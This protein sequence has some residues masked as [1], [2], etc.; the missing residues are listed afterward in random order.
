MVPGAA[1]S[2]F[3]T[4]SCEGL[5]GGLATGPPIELAT[6][7]IPSSLAPVDGGMI[8]DDGG[9]GITSDPMDVVSES[10]EAFRT[11]LSGVKTRA[12]RIKRKK[13]LSV[14]PPDYL[15]SGDSD[16]DVVKPSQRKRIIAS[17]DREAEESVDL[18]SD[19]SNKGSGKKIDN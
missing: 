10:Q 15:L 1:G 4:E 9:S 8:I 14:S 17:E 5:M 12:G 7:E 6:V 11:P 2:T 16:E 13:E 19:A 3:L 18:T